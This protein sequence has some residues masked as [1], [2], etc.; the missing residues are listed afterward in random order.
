[1]VRTLKISTL[2]LVMMLLPGCPGFFN[3]NPKA[4]YVASSQVFASVVNTLTIYRNEGKFTDS[5][6]AAI[7]VAI[8]EGQA[9]L[10]QWEASI[11]AGQNVPSDLLGSFNKVLQI[12]ID[13]EKKGGT[14]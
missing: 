7:T 4:Q 2:V 13:Y 11:N 1:M 10:L 12:L 6:V 9:I 3:S 14:K 8:H 5:Q